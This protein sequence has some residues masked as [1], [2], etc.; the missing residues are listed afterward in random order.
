VCEALSS[1][2]CTGRLP[3][4]RTAPAAACV[5]TLSCH[6]PRAP[7]LPL[8]RAAA[9]AVFAIGD[10]CDRGRGRAMYAMDH[11]DAVVKQI[12]KLASG[13]AA[14]VLPQLWPASKDTGEACSCGARGAA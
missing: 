11:A 2:D 3:C 8:R 9:P 13:T 12:R 10:C 1:E 7:A 6:G 4:P 5:A 14:A